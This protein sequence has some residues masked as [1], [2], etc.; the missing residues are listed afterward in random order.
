MEAEN[1]NELG[2]DIMHVLIVS[3][4]RPLFLDAYLRSLPL[5]NLDVTVLYAADEAYIEAYDEIAARNAIVSFVHDSKPF[6]QHVQ[7]WLDTLHTTE[8]AMITVDDN[9][10]CGDIDV[11]AVCAA[12]RQA[13]MVT[14]RQHPG[15]YRCHVVGWED[16]G[17]V[18]V[19]P[20][21]GVI[22]YDPREYEG[23][24]RYTFEVSGS[25]ARRNLWK[26]AVGRMP[27]DAERVNDLEAAGR[28][29]D[30]TKMACLPYAPLTNIHVDTFKEAASFRRHL[31]DVC[32][33][34]KALELYQSGKTIDVKKTF[35][36]RDREGTTHVLKLF[37]E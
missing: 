30:V 25:A 9:I 2:E 37:L 16:K 11:S 24:W 17:P 20:V 32:T 1:T 10:C 14:L 28:S 12:L 31:D 23:T 6:K 18:G 21:D 34:E 4:N 22:Y 19:K 3:R 7:Q 33:D 35:E 8:A 5:F 15:I 13:D 36:E 29:L 27:D 26:A